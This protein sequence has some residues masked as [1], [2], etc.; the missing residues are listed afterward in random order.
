MRTVDVLVA[1]KK[2]FSENP[3]QWTTGNLHAVRNA[4]N[5]FCALGGIALQSGCMSELGMQARNVFVSCTSGPV[6]ADP[7]GP[8][9]YNPVFSKI[10]SLSKKAIKSY[11][12]KGIHLVAGAKATAYLAR[13]VKD[14]FGETKLIVGINDNHNLGLPA[15]MK[16]LDLAIARAKRRHIKGDK[17]RVRAKR[18][19][20]VEQAVTQ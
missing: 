20:A 1:T 3:D 8:E 5:C 11:E 10:E 12:S 15:I 9:A 14:L 18:A 19:V 6:T 13:A 16:A 7:N 17:G 2:F 4:K